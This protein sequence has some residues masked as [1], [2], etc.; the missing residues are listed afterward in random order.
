NRLKRVDIGGGLPQTLTSVGNNPGGGT[1][2][3]QGVILFAG[4]GGGLFRIPASGGET[5][6]VTK[7]DSPRRFSHRRPQFLANG[8]QFVQRGRRRGISLG[9]ASKQDR[10]RLV[11]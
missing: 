9:V 3:P 6:A 2:S 10:Q 8:R 4:G 5:V 7:L 1:W 11:A